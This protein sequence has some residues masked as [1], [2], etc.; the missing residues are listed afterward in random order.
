M[1]TN[2]YGRTTHQC[3]YYRT[4]WYV[5]TKHSIHV[6]KCPE[7]YHRACSRIN[8]KCKILIT[9]R[10]PS[11]SNCASFNRAIA[12]KKFWTSAVMSMIPCRSSDW[13]SSERKLIRGTRGMLDVGVWA[14]EGGAVTETGAELLSRRVT[15]LAMD[16]DFAMTRGLVGVLVLWLGESAPTEDLRGD[17]WNGGESKGREGERHTQIETGR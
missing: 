12:A 16:E 13:T 15:M 11:A 17:I 5:Q 7:T 4:C 8:K 9:C 6:K 2:Y 1:P 3:D 10:V 14:V